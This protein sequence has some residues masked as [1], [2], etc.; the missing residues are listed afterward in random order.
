MERARAVLFYGGH[1][2]RGGIALMFRKAIARELLV[3]VQ[4]HAVTSYLCQN[5][6]GG[7]RVAARITLDEGSLFIGE[8]LDS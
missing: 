4:H 5:T 1:V 8:P 3:K 7:N 2:L 6:G